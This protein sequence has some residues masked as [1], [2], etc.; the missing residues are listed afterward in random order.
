[1]KPLLI[2]AALLMVPAAASA[3]VAAGTMPNTFDR[4]A[5]AAP[6]TAPRPAQGPAQPTRSTTPANPASEDALRGFITSVQN[7][8]I[9]Y[10]IFT[11]DLAAKVREQAPTITPLI[12]GFGTVQAVDFVGSEGGTDLYVVTFATAATE[13]MIGF[14]D[15]KIA[16]L[17]FRP[18][19]D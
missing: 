9:D 5:E 11:T 18:A 7:D 1:M 8:G 17:L 16:A 6:R 2:A 13:W 3:Q 10:A 12:K 19:Q 15:D 4:P 14:Q